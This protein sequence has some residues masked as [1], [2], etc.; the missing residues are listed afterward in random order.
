MRIKYFLKLVFTIFLVTTL[1][2]LSML[3]IPR[4]KEFF[5]SGKIEMVV[6]VLKLLGSWFIFSVLFG[7]TV[8]LLQELIQRWGKQNGHLDKIILY[9][10]CPF[11][12]CVLIL[13]FVGLQL[14]FLGG[15]FFPANFNDNFYVLFGFSML[16]FVIGLIVF[17]LKIFVLKSHSNSLP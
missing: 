6:Y 4:F 10:A 17:F 14:R 8:F 2:D 3:M 7:S 11:I 13:T 16:L 5:V 1:L 9:L 12:F 15:F